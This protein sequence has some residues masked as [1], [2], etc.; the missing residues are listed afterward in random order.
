VAVWPQEKA[1]QIPVPLGEPGPAK[2][3]ERSYQTGEKAAQAQETKPL[4]R[5]GFLKKIKACPITTGHAF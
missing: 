5:S 1:L 3:A 4:P 2:Q